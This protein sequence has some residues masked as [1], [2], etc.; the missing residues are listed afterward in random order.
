M[1]YLRIN[2]S[3]REKTISGEVHGSAGDAFIAALSAEPETLSEL[4]HALS[5]FIKPHHEESPFARFSRYKNYEPYDAGILVIDLV[6]RVIACESTYCSPSKEGEVRY[7]NGHSLTDV[8]ARFRLPDDWTIVRSIPEYEGVAARKREERLKAVPLDAREILYGRELLEFLFREMSAA[9][10]RDD[11]NLFGDVHERWLMTA[12]E[13]LQG[14]AP[15]EVLLEKKELIDA[16]LWSRELQWSFSGECPPFLSREFHAYR[17]GGFGTNE[18][19]VYYDLIR[20]LLEEI[21]K[22]NPSV[23]ELEKLKNDWLEMPDPESHGRTPAQIIERERRRIPPAMS[24][25]EALID[26]DCPVCR[27]MSEDFETPMFWHLDGCNMDDRFAFSFYR[28]R[29]EWEAEQRRYK[30]FNEEFRR[31]QDTSFFDENTFIEE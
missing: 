21:R 20:F 3:D 1:S 28:T 27:M 26:H 17:F 22:Q 16:D 8:P 24:A 10:N 31:K 5:R 25:E 13:D 12:R 2:L 30:E 7:H 19:V 29:E 15:R 4:E 23:E 6:A 14:R 9:Q 11:E 18:L